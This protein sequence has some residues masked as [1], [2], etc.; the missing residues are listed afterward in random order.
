MMTKKTRRT[1]S[2]E[3]RLESA[4]LVVD[5]N[6]AIREAA[7]AVGVGQ[8]TMDKWVRQLV[9]QAWLLPSMYAGTS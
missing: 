1:F 9:K 3:F 2:S 6:Y 5:E 8:S 4:Q 7:M